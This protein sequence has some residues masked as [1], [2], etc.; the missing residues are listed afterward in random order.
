LLDTFARVSKLWAPKS[1]AR[2]I[3]AADC[4]IAIEVVAG[5][6]AVRVPAELWHILE[7]TEAAGSEEANET[8]HHCKQT[9]MACHH[10]VEADHLKNVIFCKHFEE[11]VIRH[12]DA[13]DS[14][15]SRAVLVQWLQL[16]RRRWRRGWQCK[17]RVLVFI[18]SSARMCFTKAGWTRLGSTA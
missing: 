8:F 12:P 1:K 14:P 16:R 7:A 2:N 15:L 11:V 17:G 9:G 5:L 4:F 13:G 6:A 3:I 10:V 18:D